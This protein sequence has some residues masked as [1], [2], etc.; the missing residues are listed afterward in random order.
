MIQI[1]LEILTI[2]T[3]RVKEVVKV[4]KLEIFMA[5]ILNSYFFIDLKIKYIM[6][7]FTTNY[8]LIIVSMPRRS[9]YTQ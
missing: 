3:V 9:A 8:F 7:T 5:P 2:N 4:H 1:T 6:I